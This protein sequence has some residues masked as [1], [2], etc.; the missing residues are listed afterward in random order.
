MKE[1]GPISDI[2]WEELE[3]ELFSP[4]EISASDER[5]AEYSRIIAQSLTENGKAKT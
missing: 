4:E 3:K 2:T 1:N 5:V